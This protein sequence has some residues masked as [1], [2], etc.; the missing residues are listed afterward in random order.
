MPAFQR[1]TPTHADEVALFRHAIVGDLVTCDLPPG[2]LIQELKRRA[3]QRYRPPSS[4]VTRTYH[5]KTLQ[6]WLMAARQGFQ[7][8]YA[9][10]RKKG[11][12]L[13]VADDARQ[14]LLDMRYE[15]PTASSD[16]LLDEAVRN[17]VVEQGTLSPATLRRLYASAGVSRAAQTR[18]EAHKARRRWEADR[19]CKIWHADVCHVWM[20]GPGGE[21]IKAY[22]HGILDDHSRYIVALRACEAESEN[23]LLAVLVEALLRFPAPDVLYVD[24]GATYR[25]QLLTLAAAKLGIRVVHPQPHDPEARGKMERFWR[26]MRQRLIDVHT[27][28]PTLHDLNA[29][30]LAWLDV[31]YHPRRHGGLLGQTPKKRFHAGVQ[32]LAAPR[33]AQELA[34]ALVIERTA[35]V[36]KDAT[37]SVS[38]KLYEV[39]GRYLAG[40]IVEVKLDPFT[41]QALSAS[42]DGQAVRF[43]ACDPKANAKRGRGEA[44]VSPPATRRFDRVRSLLAAAREVIDA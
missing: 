33:T 16:L 34:A 26:T 41:E 43:S 22:V 20:R 3:A 13:G 42:V 37:F 14:L 10:S 40:K 28:G 2:A 9:S 38:G 15:H 1:P 7:E 44:A 32:D 36:R 18:P 23:D 27:P 31:D 30:L 12:A 19:V 29:A 25:G 6:R 39:T 11:F 35:K 8:L 24:N 5:Y 21:T 4:T 17:G